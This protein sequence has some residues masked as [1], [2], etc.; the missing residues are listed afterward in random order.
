MTKR[1]R[2][3]AQLLAAPGNLFG[4]HAE[5]VG[6]GEHVFEYVDGL[7][8]VFLVVGARARQGFD[9]PEGAHAEGAFAASDA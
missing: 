1:L 3:I 4:K 6:K 2:G 7:D 8:E 9:E 5:V